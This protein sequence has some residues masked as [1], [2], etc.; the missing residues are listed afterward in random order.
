M[1]TIEVALVV[2]FILIEC[3]DVDHLVIALIRGRR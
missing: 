1:R 2:L 3:W